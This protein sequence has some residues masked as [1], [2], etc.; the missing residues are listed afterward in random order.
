MPNIVA[1]CNRSAQQLGGDWKA[2]SAEEEE[3]EEEEEIAKEYD[4]AEAVCNEF[5]EEEC[6]CEYVKKTYRIYYCEMDGEEC[7]VR[8]MIPND[9]Q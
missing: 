4:E 8:K 6:A 1:F 7:T 3:E 5:T 2:E 9:D